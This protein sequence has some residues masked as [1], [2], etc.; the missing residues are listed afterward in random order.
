MGQGQAKE[1]K[2][3]ERVTR[4]VRGSDTPDSGEASLTP[5]LL[6]IPSCPPPPPQ[7]LFGAE[8]EAAAGGG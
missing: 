2:G 7:L 3:A 8:R 1:A 4:R 5:R 6:L